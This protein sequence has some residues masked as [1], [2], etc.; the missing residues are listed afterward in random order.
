MYTEDS[1]YRERPFTEEGVLSSYGLWLQR[2]LGPAATNVAEAGG[3]LVILTRSYHLL[4]LMRFLRDQSHCQYK[5]LVDVTAVDYPQREKRF[6]VVYM[7]LSLRYSSRLR[8]KVSVDPFEGLPSLTGLY[9]S[10][11]WLEREVWDMFGVFFHDHPDL[12]RLLTDYGFE[13]H[14]LRKDFPLTGYTEV[15]YD[16]EKKRV[17]CEPLELSQEF[18][19]FDFQSP[20]DQKVR[21]AILGPKSS[22]D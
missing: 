20:W 1:T 17:V 2:V 21:P 15:R 14:P 10:A 6:E 18:R 12:R 13:G 3:E 11:N 8:V 22:N 4:N 19:A 7:L 9:N 5:V 16:E